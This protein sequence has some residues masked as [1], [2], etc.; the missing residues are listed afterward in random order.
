[1]A[2]AASFFAAMPFAVAVAVPVTTQAVPVAYN[3]A[4][5][6]DL[7]QGGSLAMTGLAVGGLRCRRQQ[8]SQA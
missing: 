7:A 3:E 4:V 6:G 5:D 1:M 2:R 8:N